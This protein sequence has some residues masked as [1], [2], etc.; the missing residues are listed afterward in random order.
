VRDRPTRERLL[1][2]AWEI[3]NDKGVAGLTLAE[4][5]ARAGVSR[6]AVYLH[7][8][9]RAS[10]LVEMTRRVDHASGFVERFAAARRLPPREAFHAVLAEW[11]AYVPVILPVLRALEAAS[12]TGDDGGAAYVERMA[13][14]RR[15]LGLVVIA[16]D[17]DRALAP[18]W[19]VE[20]ATDWIWAQAHPATYHHLVAE[21]GWAR[22]TAVGT[23]I[24]VLERTLIRAGGDVPVSPDTTTR[25]DDY[26]T[27]TAGTRSAFRNSG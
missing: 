21:R 7:F 13:D 22:E 5:G 19:D 9:N 17:R 8:R 15:A 1:A 4:V 6:Q 11:F 16:L 14:W 24:A 26:G 18:G 23:I 10:L 12:T 2:A 27:A 3:A 20:T 25:Y